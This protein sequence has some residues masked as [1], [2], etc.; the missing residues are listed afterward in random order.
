M[1]D[2]NGIE[3]NIEDAKQLLVDLKLVQYSGPDGNEQAIY[4]LLRDE[5]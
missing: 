4:L 5:E 2:V 1:I 3:V